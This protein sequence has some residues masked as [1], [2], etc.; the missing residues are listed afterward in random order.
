M[1]RLAYKELVEWKTSSGRKPLVLYGGRQVGKTWLLKEFGQKEY[2]RTLCINFDIDR[3]IHSFFGDDISPQTI[4]RG[5]ES[6][7]NEKIEPH[8]TLLIFDEIQECQR[9]KD[10]LKYF[11]ENAPQYHIAAAGSF[12]GIAGGKFPVGQVNELTLYPLS[13]GEFMEATERGLLAE[14]LRK[15]DF[16]LITASH[17]MLAEKL[18]EYLFTGGMPEAVNAFAET[19]N[20]SEV[21]RVQEIILNNYKNDFSK[22]ISAANIPKV[23]ML[24]DSIPVHLAKEKKKFIYKEVKA[25]G[26]ASEF[27]NAMNWL[28]S[29]GLVYKVDRT[30]TPKIPLSAY[31]EREHFK[32][33]MLDVGLLGAKAGL[34][35]SIFLS[36]DKTMFTE[37]KGA[38]AEQFVLQELKV[39]GNSPIYYWGNESGKAEVDFIMQHKNEIIPIEVK[40][41]VN[42]KSQSLS[43]YLEKYQPGHAVRIS[44]KK[45]GQSG[46]LLSV[47]LY[48]IG[49]LRDLLETDCLRRTH[50]SNP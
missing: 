41:S 30:A 47:P 31:E 21:R 2:K 14:T 34:D 17:E 20:F 28:I 6:H 24:W 49:G 25:D 18:K 50:T 15:K 3:K 19:G 27:E 1:I 5:L 12:L 42:T 9:A 16:P 46:G 37:F 39:L 22:H 10:S 45:F 43:V 40:S 8:D 7:F 13:F 35:F 4:I 32:I 23:R 38:L 11:N 33:Y 44:L 36:G 48:M 26:R 29:T